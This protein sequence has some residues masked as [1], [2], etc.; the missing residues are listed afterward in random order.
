[1]FQQMM[2]DGKVTPSNIRKV[3]DQIAKKTGAY[4]MGD[5]N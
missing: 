4:P 3:K 5:T 2:K 1:M